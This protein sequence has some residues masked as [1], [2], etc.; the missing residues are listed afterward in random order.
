MGDAAVFLDRDDTLVVDSGFIDHPDKV[1]LVP[2][3]ADAVR[4]L[5]E[6]GFK[7]VVASNQSGVARGYFDETRLK[8]IHD[9]MRQLLAGHGAAVDA[10]YYCPYLDGPE[11]TVDA[12]RRKSN[13]RK[14]EPGMMYRAA[15]DLNLDLSRSWMIGD[16]PRDV[17]AGRAA[18]CRTILIANGEPADSVDNNAADYCVANLLDA[19]AV[20][21]R[22][23][24]SAK[25][26][27]RSEFPSA[28]AAS[29]G[30][31]G[32][33]LNE[34]RDLLE[35]RDRQQRFDDFSV[36]R[37]LATLLQMLALFAVGWGILALLSDDTSM[38]VPRLLL[39]CFLQIS[40]IAALLATRR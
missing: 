10:V 32:D 31:I 4:R 9:R 28:P 33:R 26:A 5:R 34:I 22:E 39:G 40:V 2:G 12:Y 36:A 24:T 7:I 6:R 37:L 19:V 21:E 35:H 1:V 17:Q 18:G 16:A 8:E 25:S 14:P 15:G 23:T 27:H 38:A 11:A 3:A 30:D 20:V 13:L 29:A